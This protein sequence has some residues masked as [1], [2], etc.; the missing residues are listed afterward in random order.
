MLVWEPAEAIGRWIHENGGGFVFPG[1]YTALGW[2]EDGRLVAGLA[3]SHYNGKH[4]L[5]NGAILEGR[6]PRQFLRAFLFYVF[7]QLGLPRV[8]F[9]VSSANIRSI[10]LMRHLGAVQEATL[11][12]ADPSGDLLIFA[13]WP[14]NCKFWKRFNEGRQRT[15]S[16]ESRGDHPSTRAREP[17]NV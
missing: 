9:L 11:R 13:L 2:V 15:A 12:D 14:E 6:L 7:K 16:P 8:T 5:V 10:N 17:A 4:V 3:M 1:S